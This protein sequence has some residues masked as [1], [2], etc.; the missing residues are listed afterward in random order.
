MVSLD[1]GEG[2]SIGISEL[3]IVAYRCGG[4]NGQECL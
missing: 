4:I 1:I 2:N 3:L